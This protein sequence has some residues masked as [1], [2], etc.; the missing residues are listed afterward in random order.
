[1]NSS[2]V[3][4]NDVL[5]GKI[6]GAHGV[7]GNF[8]IISYAE[9]LSVFQPGSEVC[10]APG[11][12]REKNYEINWVKPHTKV[13]LLSL[14]GI[15]TRDQAQ[16]LV[17][18]DLFIDKSRLPDTDEGTYYWFDLIGLEVRSDD[19]KYLGLLESI[20]Q[21]G[22]NDVYVVTDQDSEILI[23]AIESVV[24]QIDLENKRMLVRLPEGL[25]D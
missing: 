6:V 12:G 23:P 16:A 5:I 25:V 1:L 4:N 11:P 10:V 21:T 9:S 24:L 3:K 2:A 13:D 15:G 8:K 20:I 14:K 22:G 17:G 7:N 19:G 18:S